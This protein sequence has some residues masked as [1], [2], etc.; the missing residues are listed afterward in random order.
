MTTLESLAVCTP[1]VTLPVLQNVPALATGMLAAMQEEAHRL[2]LVEAEAAFASTVAA[3]VEEYAATVVSL[4]G[5]DVRASDQSGSQSETSTLTLL[6]KAIAQS[7][8]VL[9]NDEH[10]G[11]E[12]ATILKRLVLA[13]Q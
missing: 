9:Y 6:R 5:S 13:N 8:H 10:S 11:R 4:L 1:V 12:L 2:R 7:V 3:S